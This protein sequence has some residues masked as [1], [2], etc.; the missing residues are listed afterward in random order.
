MSRART[1][2][3]A[4]SQK[5][6]VGELS[7]QEI[8]LSQALE[9]KYKQN[10]LLTKLKGLA[11]QTA[12]SDSDVYFNNMKLPP[13]PSQERQSLILCTE[14]HPM[15]QKILKRHIGSEYGV[16][17]MASNGKEAIRLVLDK[18]S[19]GEHYKLLISDVNMPELN[20]PEAIRI[21]QDY[22]KKHQLHPMIIIV[23]TEETDESLICNFRLLKE[24]YNTIEKLRGKVSA[25]TRENLK[26]SG[27]DIDANLNRE[28]FLAQFLVEG[29]HI[30]K[31]LSKKALK[32]DFLNA[33]NK[34]PTLDKHLK[35]YHANLLATEQPNQ[36]NEMDRLGKEIISSQFGFFYKPLDDNNNMSK[37]AEIS[38]A[39]WLRLD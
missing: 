39:T 21:L 8:S 35:Q 13:S 27:I 4:I 34:V 3:D 38:V 24:D 36:D 19:Q 18:N 6:A 1:K 31:V 22:E 26:A 5:S 37:S 12:T 28:Q 10:E 32:A 33:I 2:V 20:G 15:N 14:D 9:D 7:K 30:N 11:L 29:I 23:Y 16:P 17:H 25:L